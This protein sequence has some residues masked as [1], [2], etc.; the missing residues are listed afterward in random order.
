MEEIKRRPGRPPRR[1]DANMDSLAEECA[2]QGRDFEEV[3]A[4]RD[5]ER[6]IVARG[7]TVMAPHPTETQI[8]RQGEDGRPVRA[9]ISV[10]YEEGFEI[11]LDKKEAE[12]LIAL[13]IVHRPGEPEIYPAALSEGS[14]VVELGP[15]RSAVNQAMRT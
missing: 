1:L 5:R 15:P 12:R 6:V 11:E 9:P 2:E 10:T 8:V 3:L 7:R 4:S 14:R 13:G